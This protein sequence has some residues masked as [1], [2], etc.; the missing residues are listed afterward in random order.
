M[1]NRRRSFEY[2]LTMAGSG[3]I[4]GNL[5]NRDEGVINNLIDL[6]DPLGNFPNNLI[7]DVTEETKLY[8]DLVEPQ[9][10]LIIE[11]DKTDKMYHALD[12]RL[13]DMEFSKV[14]NTVMAPSRAQLQSMA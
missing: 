5:E 8:H 14:S 12:E 9:E 2:E 11:L 3:G 10:D 4:I 1:R 6:D 13:K 7:V